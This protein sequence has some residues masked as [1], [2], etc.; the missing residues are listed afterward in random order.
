M[1]HC[2]PSTSTTPT[3]SPR[4]PCRDNDLIVLRVHLSI[5]LSHP[6]APILDR[7]SARL[8]AW[9]SCRR[10]SSPH[11]VTHHPHSSPFFL[12]FTCNTPLRGSA[13]PP[14]LNIILLDAARQ[15]DRRF[16]QLSN[17]SRS[18]GRPHPSYI[19]HPRPSRPPL[20]HP[21][22]LCHPPTATATATSEQPPTPQSPHES[23]DPA[24]PSPPNRAHRLRSRFRLQ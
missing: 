16:F 2:S 12:S 6:P 18:R 19:T 3:P 8:L 9:R 7:W 4:Q 11:R 10:Q 24:D 13:H 23:P 22:T 5:V 15:T 17:H 1:T 21:S 14:G 20:S